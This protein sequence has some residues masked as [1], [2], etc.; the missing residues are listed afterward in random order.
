VQAAETVTIV[1]EGSAQADACEM[2]RTGVFRHRGGRGVEGIGMSS[3]SADAAIR[4]CCFWNTRP[5][6]EI[7]VC[8]SVRTGRWYACVRYR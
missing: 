1:V 5:V 4:R 3:E 6:R 8:R 2:A 7:G